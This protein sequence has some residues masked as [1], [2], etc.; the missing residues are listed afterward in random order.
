M[1]FSLRIWENRESPAERKRK[2]FFF[3]LS[4]GREKE[5]E[6][7]GERKRERGEFFFRAVNMQRERMAERK[8]EERGRE[9][10][11]RERACGE[12]G[13]RRRGKSFFYYYLFLFFFF[14]LLCIFIA[15]YLPKLDARFDG[16]KKKGTV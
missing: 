3:S 12:K 5:R 4:G 1:F 6:N 16:A 10:G 9:G 14:L 11:E 13:Q 15:V 7:D 2:P 8:W